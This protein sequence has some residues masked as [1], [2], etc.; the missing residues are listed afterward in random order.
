MGIDATKPS[1]YQPEK[2]EE[3]ERARPMGSG[4]VRLADFL[5]AELPL[6]P[7]R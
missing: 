5:A 1:L 4:R 7:R 6:A 3:F 2:R